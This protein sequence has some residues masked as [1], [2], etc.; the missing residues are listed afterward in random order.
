MPP[1]R[2]AIGCLPPTETFAEIMDANFLSVVK[3]TNMILPHMRARDQGHIVFTNSS[4]GII[5]RSLEGVSQRGVSNC[6]DGTKETIALQPLAM[7][8]FPPTNFSPL[9]PVHACVESIFFTPRRFLFLL[10]SLPAYFNFGGFNAYA[11]SKVAL[12]SYANL[13]RQDL[14]GCGSK[15]VIITSIHPGYIYTD[16]HRNIS[17]TLVDASCSRD[18]RVEWHQKGLDVDV[19]ASLIIR[20]VSRNLEEAWMAVPT[21]LLQMYIGFYLPQCVR[22]VRRF[23]AKKECALSSEYREAVVSQLTGCTSS[24]DGAAKQAK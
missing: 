10:L 2:L 3:L 24:S 1:G 4:S 6:T 9:F 13:L 16:I 23:S 22:W 14:R 5:T 11:T 20:A 21:G 8:P 12:L 7:I 15:G 18:A 19:A 17:D